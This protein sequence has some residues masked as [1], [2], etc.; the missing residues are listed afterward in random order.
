MSEG[1]IPNN[2][3]II[4][5]FELPT[6]TIEGN[7]YADVDVDVSVSGLSPM[8]IIG[9]MI[10]GQVNFVITYVSLPSSNTARLRIRNLLATQASA[11]GGSI[12][13]LYLV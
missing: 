7:S 9:W 10:N 2:R 12:T 5:T 8:G 6:I 13:V 1:Y 4:K 3:P 11:S